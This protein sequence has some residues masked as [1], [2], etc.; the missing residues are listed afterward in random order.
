MKNWNDVV[1]TARQELNTWFIDQCRNPDK[2]FFWKYS[3]TT[4]TD[5][6]KIWI[7]NEDSEK[8]GYYLIRLNA[9]K[10]IDG[11]LIDFLKIAGKLPILEI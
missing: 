5:A 6:G 4:G 1:E 7:D 9:G 11:N 8:Y 3:E 10:D 2:M